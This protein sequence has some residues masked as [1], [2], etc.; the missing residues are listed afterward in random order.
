[1][2]TLSAQ[3]VNKMDT[4]AGGVQDPENHSGRSKGGDKKRG[5][6]RRLM[7]KGNH[8]TG[9][10]KSYWKPAPLPQGIKVIPHGAGDNIYLLLLF[11][12]RA[13]EVIALDLLY[14][15]TFP[16]VQRETQQGHNVHFSY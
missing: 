15:H 6:L 8:G 1:M 5:S 11:V 7:A 13:L 4:D 12:Y 2:G 16:E 10:L 9:N 3:D 14:E